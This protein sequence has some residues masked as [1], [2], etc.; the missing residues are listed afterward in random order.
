M[1]LS[2][3]TALLLSSSTNSITSAFQVPSIASRGLSTTTVSSTADGSLTMEDHQQSNNDEEDKS[4]TFLRPLYDPLGL[5]PKDSIERLNGQIFSLEP[6]VTA[7]KPVI[8]PLNL[9]P[10][11]TASVILDDPVMSEA[12]PFMPRPLHLTGEL[13]GDVGFD[14]LGFASN[15]KDEMK[16]HQMRQA[17]VKHGRLAMLAAAGW[18]LSELFDKQ[19]ASFLHLKP[20][21]GFG[22]KVPSLLNGGLTKVSPI[23]WGIVLALAS[24]IEL[25]EQ[26]VIN[27]K[28]ENADFIRL[29]GDL[30]F[31]PLNLYPTSLK[32]QMNMQ[33]AEIKH[34]RLAM[35]AV[36][37]FAIQECVTKIGVVNQTPLF[38][39]PISDYF[40]SLTNTGYL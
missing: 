39:H 40:E 30:G 35:L 28:D 21:L 38:F 33:L 25:Y 36:T 12:L 3:A 23:Y 29:P 14:P 31:D 9:Y 27:N 8:D 20:L 15:N 32:D 10:K 16:V 2:L 4:V 5:Y 6:E 11:D 26:Q 22:D 24:G 19:I 13:A 37:G 17:E 1:K 7:I 18:P 34:G